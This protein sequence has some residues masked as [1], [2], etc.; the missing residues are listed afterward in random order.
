MFFSDESR[1]QFYSN[2][3]KL[4]GPSRMVAP[5]PKHSPAVMTWGAFS[6]RGVT[7]LAFISESVESDVYIE[8]MG[9]YSID[10]ASELYPERYE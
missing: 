8:V 2:F 7:P 6:A 5:M 3:Q 1:F 10:K 4:I 9:D